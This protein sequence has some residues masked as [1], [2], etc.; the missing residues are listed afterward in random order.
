MIP[1]SHD[2]NSYIQ[3]FVSNISNTKGN[4]LKMQLTR[5]PYKIQ[6]HY[7]SNRIIAV[8]N[9]L[10]NDVVSADSN[11]VFKNQLKISFVIIGIFD[12]LGKPTLPQMEVV[13]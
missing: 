2:S 10:P 3:F 11:N 12:L 13:P 4:K 9:S 1:G 8:R 7:F 5:I 6:K